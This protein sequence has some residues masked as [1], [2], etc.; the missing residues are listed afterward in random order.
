MH[1]SKIMRQTPR[2][3][4]APPSTT[5]AWLDEIDGEASRAWVSERNEATERAFGDDPAFLRLVDD[6][7]GILDAPDRVPAVSEAAG[8]LYNIWVGP[9][10]PRGLWRRT[11]WE[12]Y[13]SGAPTTGS[14]ALAG[15][16]DGHGAATRW[17]T[18]L[19]IDELSH[20]RDRH[21]TWGG[22][23]VLAE[24]PLA[25]RRALVTLSE[26]GSDAA[27]TEELDLDTGR[28]VAEADGGFRR[29]A[30][31]GSLT[32]G[33]ADGSAV[34]V[35]AD[36]GEGSLSPAGFPRQVRRLR[37]GQRIEEAEVL[38]T[39]PPDAIVAKASRDAWGRTWLMAMPSAGAVRVWLL[40]DDVVAPSGEEAA[41]AALGSGGMVVPDGAIRLD[42]P[43][44]A[45]A[46]V[47]A[48]WL[49]VELREPCR[50]A[51]SAHPAGTL[52]GARLD[53]YLAG[54]RTMTVLFSPTPSSALTAAAWTRHH[55]VLTVLDDVASR[56]EVRTPPASGNG[57]WARHGIDL[58]GAA[59]PPGRS[60]PA[61]PVGAHDAGAA[62]GASGTDGADSTELRPGRALLTASTRAV[63]SRDT[64]YL[65]ISA[66]GWTTPASLAV[67]RLTEAGEI[68]GMSVLRQ[69][70]ALYD[71]R[72]VGVTQHMAT[73]EDG[74][75]IPYFQVGRP[76]SGPGPTLLYAYG[77]FGTSQMPCYQPLTGKG[78]LERGGTYVVANTRGGGEY[79]PGWHLTA[80]GPGRHRVLEDLAAVARSL[81][82]RGATTP[83]RLVVH[84]GSAGGLLVGQMLTRHPDLIGGAVAEVPLTDMSRYTHLLAGAF[85][86]SEFGDPDDPDQC[87]WMRELSPLHSLEA[88]RVYPPLLL[89][90]STRD[91][92]VHPVHARAMAHR[93]LALGQDVSYL[94]TA[95]GGHLGVGSHTQRAW[96]T[97]LVQEFAWRAA[98]RRGRPGSDS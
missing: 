11:T 50:V 77:A 75:R 54:D 83:E 35:S 34:L 51:G 79:G 18:L 52:L 28:F 87:A 53:D 57:E 37:R 30:S 41:R 20:A 45:S 65:W 89:L 70:P 5:P 82:R 32:W 91:D 58:T 81:I 15:R 76:R 21:L 40:P 17:E 47:G 63:R 26:E 29:P 61:D 84:G 93:L 36:F 6:M 22:A 71:A 12:S 78:W 31:H 62:H 72:G 9:A 85:W 23:Q 64:D 42:V 3:A 94:E 90:T 95:E 74:T 68:T 80:T 8:M 13:A 88:G 43:E 56:L 55:L 4:A 7:Q 69:A 46:G 24:G 19:D 10:H 27:T 16:G 38:L 66:E 49:T 86:A 14:G 92:R 73:S 59:D 39:I 60:T 33:D 98:T 44:S 97:A 25:G 96:T 48:E 67:G 2:T 1:Q